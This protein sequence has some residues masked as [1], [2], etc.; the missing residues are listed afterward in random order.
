MATAESVLD[1]RAFLD[2][3][4]RAVDTWSQEADQLVTQAGTAS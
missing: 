1:L 3:L 4:S 2:D